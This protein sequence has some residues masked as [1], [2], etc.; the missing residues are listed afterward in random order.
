VPRRAGSAVAA[1]SGLLALGACA[2]ERATERPSLRNDEAS[3]FACD[4]GRCVQRHVRLPDDGEWRCAE[5]AGVVW[6]AGGEPPAGVVRA[7]AD[8]GYVCGRRAGARHPA[9]ERICVDASPD[10]PSGLAGE[11]A[12]HFAEERGVRRVCERQRSAVVPPRG[13]RAPDCWLDRDCEGGPCDRGRC[14]GEGG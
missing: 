10:Y 2:R 14:A 3:E 12:C 9:G 5:R 6:C 4:G 8:R 1:L 7:P 13:R 11:Y